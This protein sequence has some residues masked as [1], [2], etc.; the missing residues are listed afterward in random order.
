[1]RGRGEWVI[2]KLGLSEDQAEERNKIHEQK[3]AENGISLQGHFLDP[4]LGS[5]VPTMARGL[6]DHGILIDKII[7]IVKDRA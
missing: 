5:K 6:N 3:E 4:S 7:V 1:M 2:Q